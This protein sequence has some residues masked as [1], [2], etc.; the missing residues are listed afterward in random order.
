MTKI[1]VVLYI[2]LSMLLGAGYVM[3]IVKLTRTDFQSPHKAEAIR[4][5][6]LFPPVGIVTGWINI[7]D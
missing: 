3:N 2:M 1:L 7:K 6:G 5:V 4:L